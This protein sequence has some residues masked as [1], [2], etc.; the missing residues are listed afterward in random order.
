VNATR[1]L[2]ALVLAATAAV[3]ARAA[4]V[5]TGESGIL[6]APRAGDTPTRGPRSAPVTV[7]LFCNF[8]HPPCTVTEGLLRELFVRHPGG[9][10]VIYRPVAP[11]FRDA[12]TIAE[13]TLEAWAQGRFDALTELL[14]NGSGP[15]RIR[16]LDTLATRA[17]LDLQTLHAALA[18]HRHAGAV[19]DSAL[20]RDRLGISGIALWN[21]VPQNPD[22][23]IESFERAYDQA[24]QRAQ[25]LLAEGVPAERLYP[26]L[27]AQA[28][29]VRR[30]E[31]AASVD[32]ATPR[33]RVPTGGAPARGAAAPSVTLVVFNEFEC[34]VCRNHSGIVNKMIALF[35]SQVRVVWKSYPMPFHPSARRAA[36]LAACAALQGRFWELHDALIGPAVRLYAPDLD[37]AALQAGLDVDRLRRD[38]ASGRCSARVDLD[39]AEARAAGVDVSPTTFV[40]G[41]KLSGAQG[42]STLR[43]VIEAELLPGILERL[44]AST[45]ATTP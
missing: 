36:E 4:E 11:S 39:M 1:Y 45:A 28:D 33:V 38:M 21:A 19:A 7:E 10:R 20:A 16:D 3:P 23:F 25:A 18:D 40:N 44:T 14:A 24:A 42:L 12:E 30:R 8:G 41:L 22:P 31:A 26:L 17:G 29:R 13:A 34:A 6:I 27:V 15:M 2:A 5:E 9:L 43:Q 35:P 32:P 37:R